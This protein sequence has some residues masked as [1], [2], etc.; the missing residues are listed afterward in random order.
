MI[1]QHKNKYMINNKL[2]YFTSVQNGIGQVIL[3]FI[4]LNKPNFTS[5]QYGVGEVKLTYTHATLI[6]LEFLRILKR[7]LQ[8]SKKLQEYQDNLKAMFVVSRMHY[9]CI[10]VVLIT[11]NIVLFIDLPQSPAITYNVNNKTDLS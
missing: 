9:I 1:D 11:D 6:L 10:T 4:S 3:F 5:V 7:T 2:P 8:N